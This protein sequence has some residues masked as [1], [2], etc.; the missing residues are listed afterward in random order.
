[1]LLAMDKAVLEFC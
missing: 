1:V